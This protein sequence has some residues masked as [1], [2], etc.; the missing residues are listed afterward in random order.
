MKR[1]I[2]FTLAGT[3]LVALAACSETA[4]RDD[5]M[6][7]QTETQD[8]NAMMEDSSEILS[9]DYLAITRFEVPAGASLPEHQGQPRVIYSL[10]DYTLQ[11]REGDAEETTRSWKAGDIHA[12]EGLPHSLTNMGE[13]PAQFLVIVRSET[14]LPESAASAEDVA[15][16]DPQDAKVLHDESGMRIVRVDLAPGASTPT[17]SGGPRAIYALDDY[18]IDWTVGDAAPETKSWSAGDVHWHDADTHSMT[19]SGSTTASFLVIE[20]K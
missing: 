8:S 6:T 9:N 5:D 15:D 20:P 1:L 13:T 14:A 18:T 3:A 4:Q 11:W 12:H 19:N 7:A 16:S 2:S 17:H 10:D